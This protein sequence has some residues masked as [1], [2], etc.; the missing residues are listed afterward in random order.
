M[1]EV[2]L[3]SAVIGTET[4]A[5]WVNLRELADWPPRGALIGTPKLLR[6]FARLFGFFRWDGKISLEI[7]ERFPC[8]YFL[9]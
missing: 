5:S 3:G 6:G 4:H 1:R 9:R 7:L 2:T 8:S